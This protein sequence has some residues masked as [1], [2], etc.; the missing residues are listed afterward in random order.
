MTMNN[1]DDS[2]NSWDQDDFEDVVARS[3]V[4]CFESKVKKNKGASPSDRLS[5]KHLRAMRNTGL[6]VPGDS[7]IV[8]GKNNDR[9]VFDV[10]N[11]PLPINGCVAFHHEHDKNDPHYDS[12][13]KGYLQIRHFKK[14][15]LLGK[16]WER[17]SPGSLY[18]MVTL[19]PNNERVEGERSFFTVSKEG[20]VTS[21]DNTISSVRGY[22]PG[23]KHE[24]ISLSQTDPHT[25][26]QI[27]ANGSLGLQMLAD[28]RFCWAIRAKEDIAKVDL[29]CMISEIKSLLYARSL[30]MTATGRKRP[31][32]HLVE[33]HKRRIKNGTDIDITS[34]LRGQQVV[35]IGGTVFEVHPPESLKPDVSINSQ[36]KY[37][38]EN[39]SVANCSFSAPTK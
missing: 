1:T 33:A 9:W 23:V 12:Y 7:R 17:K 24:K 11:D 37:Y 26:D 28:K 8:M 2:K 31:I 4:A 34:F 35:E 27:E 3:I 14:V 15:K 6:Y 32:L 13:Y 18:E 36:D 20:I 38:N 19:C 22:L 39:N 10:D 5:V 25:I 21:C 29:G 30:P 16:N